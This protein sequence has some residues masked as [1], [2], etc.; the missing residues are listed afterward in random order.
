MPR[1]KMILVTI[2]RYISRLSVS[3]LK[4]K[5][6]T[7][8]LFILHEKFDRLQAGA[9]EIASQQCDGVFKESDHS[10]LFPDLNT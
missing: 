5:V 7:D 8:S 3:A 4:I 9:T 10:N 2:C 6:L 1:P